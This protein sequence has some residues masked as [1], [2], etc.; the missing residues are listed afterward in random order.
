MQ[1][2]YVSV[3]QIN[4]RVP[5]SLERICCKALAADPKRRF[6]S[7]LELAHALGRA[8]ARRW[9]QAAVLAILPLCAVVLVASKLTERPAKEAQRAAFPAQAARVPP[10]LLQVVS[11]DVV[12]F[13]SDPLEE[14]GRI[15]PISNA[16]REGDAVRV[17]ARLNE[18]AH[19]YLIALNPDGK[20]QLCLPSQENEAT[21][22]GSEIQF[23]ESTYFPLTDGP[24][25]Q[26]F[27]VVAG[28][29]ALPAFESWEGRDALKRR[30]KHLASED[31]HGVWVYQDGKMKPVSSGP[32][33]ALEKRFDGRPVLFHEVCDYLA[34]SPGVDVMQAVAF[35]VRPRSPATDRSS[36][37]KEE[38]PSLHR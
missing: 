7:A 20:V 28:R 3:R 9:T 4:R 29:Q 21:K 19:F 6:S 37:K 34:G 35:P 33:G 12:H 18:P 23:E 27:V 17:E 31:V 22:N 11:L 26:V 16:T 32:R 38:P 5:R 24:G 8:Q 2:E 36:G 15:G 13:R 14:V 1:A 30:W 10:P 25:M